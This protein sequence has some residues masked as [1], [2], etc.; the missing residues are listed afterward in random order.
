[1]IAVGVGASRGCPAAELAA[2]VDAALTGAGLA[3]G[4][5]A[6]LASA[7][8]KADEPAVLALAAQRGW[9]LRT[10]AAAELA[11]VAV[12]TPSA[13]VARHTGTPSV[14][15]A[16]ALLAAAPAELLVLKRRSAHATCAVAARR[17]G[18]TGLVYAAT[19]DCKGCGACLKT[20]PERALR[21]APPGFVAAGGPPLLTLVD[22]CTGCGEC[23]EICPAD[24]F[25]ALTPEEAPWPA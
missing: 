18:D 4:E 22:R 13:T 9:P 17:A 21:P 12:P 8:L 25:V 3:S 24:A 15:E 6:V 1:M 20:C 5:V 16:A 14:A 10:F 7:D 2:L 11:A 19:T 23:L